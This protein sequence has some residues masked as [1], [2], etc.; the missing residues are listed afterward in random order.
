MACY[1]DLERL[2]SELKLIAISRWGTYPFD[3]SSYSHHRMN[4]YEYDT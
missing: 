2:S 3:R 1:C 4:D